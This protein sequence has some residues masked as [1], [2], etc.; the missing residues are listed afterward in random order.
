MAQSA[1][2]NHF[3]LYSLI[4]CVTVGVCYI[5]ALDCGFVFD[6]ISAIVDNKDLRPRTPV[7]NLFL[8]DFWGTPMSMVWYIN[9]WNDIV[10]WFHL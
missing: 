7:S 2:S 5:P 10:L 3:F 9:I 8:N 6:D 1:D 4:L